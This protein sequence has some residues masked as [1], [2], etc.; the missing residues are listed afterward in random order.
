M[1]CVGLLRE[2][3]NRPLAWPR[4]FLPVSFGRAGALPACPTAQRREYRQPRG[5]YVSI[6]RP[7]H[8]CP[9][10]VCRRLRLWLANVQ[11]LVL[12]APQWE[13]ANAEKHQQASLTS[14]CA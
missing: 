14:F 9:K 4:F 8:G 13:V 2:G 5:I 10:K 1:A 12:R 6:D 3:M 7:V 11:P